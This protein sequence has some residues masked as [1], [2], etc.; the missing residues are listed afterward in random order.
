[1]K[2][3]NYVL[4]RKKLLEKHIHKGYCSDMF[5]A[6]SSRGICSY[7]IFFRPNSILRSRVEFAVQIQNSSAASMFKAIFKGMHQPIIKNLRPY[8]AY[9][10]S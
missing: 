4:A 6:A 1:V 8:S 2:V 9:R 3:F 5:L 7:C 10:K